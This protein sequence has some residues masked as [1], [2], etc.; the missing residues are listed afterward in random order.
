MD[1][2]TKSNGTCYALCYTCIGTINTSKKQVQNGH[3]LKLMALEMMLM[4][5]VMWALLKVTNMLLTLRP[6]WIVLVFLYTIP[7]Y[8]SF[9]DVK[10]STRINR[11][12]AQIFEKLSEEKNILIAR[13]DKGA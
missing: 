13:S 3:V 9:V 4:L 10:S 8:C 7:I 1:H 11:Q 6:I 12:E 5:I 2:T